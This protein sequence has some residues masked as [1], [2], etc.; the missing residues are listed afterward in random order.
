MELEKIFKEGYLNK[1][2]D[3]GIVKGW[4]RRWFV[5]TSTY[6]LL[7]S[8]DQDHSPIN[9]IYLDRETVV[10]TSP[11]EDKKY[12]K[13]C[14]QVSKKG[15]MR[16][17]F[18]RAETEEERDEW[19]QLIQ[20]QVK[21]RQAMPVG[22]DVGSNGTTIP[23]R[24]KKSNGSP[25]GTAA[26][27]PREDHIYATFPA[28]KAANHQNVRDVQSGNSHYAEFEDDPNAAP[29]RPAPTPNQTPQ[30]QNK[31]SNGTING[32]NTTEN[33]NAPIPMPNPK[34]VAKAKIE[35]PKP[36][37]STLTPDEDLTK[38]LPSTNPLAK[39]RNDDYGDLQPFF[40]ST[41][42]STTT[43]TNGT[44]QRSTLPSNSNTTHSNNNGSTIPPSV[45]RSSSTRT[46]DTDYGKKN[47]AIFLSF[48]FSCFTFF[49]FFFFL[50]T[51]LFIFHF[52]FFI[53]FLFLTRCITGYIV[54][55]LNICIL[56]G[57]C[58]SYCF[59]Y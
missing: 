17:Y 7:Y 20:D 13:C 41:P 8:K 43:T 27:T 32:N 9:C 45:M 28:L 26:N 40:E 12:A 10:A 56:I 47:S 25:S 5:L 24:T 58:Q 23:L 52:Y 50:F 54:M 29:S 11:S 14:F 36:N 34:S 55:F 35:Q 19:I 57:F 44:T 42:R 49:F 51:F 53:Y 16:I 59:V 30:T 46:A 15:Q 31:A 18:L 39:S 37:Y 33:L 6:Q 1:K 48:F 38:P 2:G 4:K 21:N 3:K 22:N